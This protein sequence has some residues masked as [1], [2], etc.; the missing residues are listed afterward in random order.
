MALHRAG[1]A[2]YY[3]PGPAF[4]SLFPETILTFAVPGALPRARA[5]GR[6]R[7]LEGERALAALLEPGFDPAAEVVLSGPGAE[8]AAAAVRP[9][10]SDVRIAELRAERVRLEAELAEPGVVVLADAYDPGWRA[11]VD[12]RDAEVMRANVAFRAVAVPAGRHVVEM[13]YRPRSVAL[14]LSL[15]AAG[16]L[17]LTALAFVSRRRRQ[18]C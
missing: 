4:P 15:S 6:A 1:L 14:G 3:V 13:R 2:A 9:G 11:R 12:G 8:G 16:L 10:P 17:A 5:V 7:A 18:A